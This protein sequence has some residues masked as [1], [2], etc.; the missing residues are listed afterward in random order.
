MALSVVAKSVFLTRL[1]KDAS[2][3]DDGV[4]FPGDVRGKRRAIIESTD[5]EDDTANSPPPPVVA[6]VL[7]RSKCTLSEFW[8]K[9][10][11][12]D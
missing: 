10:D 8:L 1:V 12:L 11:W 5:D 3:D 9:Q 2:V 4:C 7:K 6:P